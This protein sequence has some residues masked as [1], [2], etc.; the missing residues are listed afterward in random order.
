MTVCF[1]ALSL[2]DPGTVC[3]VVLMAATGFLLMR[4]SRHFAN[5]RRDSRSQQF[6]ALEPQGTSGPAGGAPDEPT[7]WAVE[8]H[9]TARTLSA[10]LDSKMS[11]LRA[12]LAEA[13]RAAARL[14]AAQAAAR[15]TARPSGTQAESLRASTRA[16]AEAES[17][18]HPRA[19]EDEGSGGRVQDSALAGD[20]ASASR[21]TRRSEEIYTLADYG[22]DAA[23]IA[24]RV[25]S[26][27]GEVELILG[28]RGKGSA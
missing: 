25:G 1:A 3:L 20:T 5:Q 27:I 8:M 4:A 18:A 15:Q 12:L 19:A 11:A 9:E 17:A 24:R 14:E 22:F 10:Q 7:R 2:S 23:E 26:P 16:T 6:S 28:L 13:D 21:R